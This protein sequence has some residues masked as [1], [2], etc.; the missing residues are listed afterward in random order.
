M[1]A[2]MQEA[3][4][5]RGGEVDGLNTLSARNTPGWWRTGLPRSA[6]SPCWTERTTFPA[7]GSV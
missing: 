7:Q 1:V 5:Q 6:C 4:E 2:A 3:V